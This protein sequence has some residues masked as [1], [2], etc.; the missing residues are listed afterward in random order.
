MLLS[1]EGIARRLG[2][3]IGASRMARQAAWLF[4]L[5]T[6]AK[7]M[8]F[9]GSAYAARCLGPA[10][11]GI[12][13]FV[14]SLSQ[15]MVVLAGGGLDTVA[16]RRIASNS[17]CTQSI[18]LAIVRFRALVLV[19][20]LPVGL[21]VAL[22]FSPWT[23]AL[24]WAAGAL[25]SAA[26]C[27]NLVFVFQ[28]LEKLP[29][30]AFVSVL[31]SALAAAAYFCFRPP[32]PVGSDL[33]VMAVSGLAGV[34]ISFWL[35]RSVARGACLNEPGPGI[36]A[37]L[38]ESR[39]Y[40]ALAIVVYCYSTMQI[41]LVGYFAGKKALGVYR[42]ALLLTAGL[43]L[44]YSS[45]NSLLLPRIVVWYKRAPELLW[46]RQKEL[47]VLFLLV[48]VA[49]SATLV[50][51][52]PLIFHR[53]LGMAFIDAILPFQIL[54]IGRMV[55]FVGQI[56][57]WS[58]AAL[59]LDRQ[60]FGAALAGAIFSVL[61]NL[62]LLPNFGIVAAAAVSLLAELLV[63][64]LCFYFVRRHLFAYQFPVS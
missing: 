9:V 53:F 46:Q 25:L 1:R 57:A 61:A 60:Y 22:F 50:L 26:V 36:K 40:W 51:F 63:H 4:G 19:A 24:A 16:A 58:L 32:M 41:P 38:V 28:G 54:V 33:A 39:P 11:L 13:A 5:N 37:L 56:F 31:T 18:T 7:G 44:F 35:F 3:R 8:A 48:G 52:T 49:V 27:F 29:T 15:L 21:G 64:G 23:Q 6:T 42:S 10:S 20:I 59:Q 45:I 62:L 43:D 14:L 55:V 17:A 12:S 30:Q 34:G 2:R 47:L